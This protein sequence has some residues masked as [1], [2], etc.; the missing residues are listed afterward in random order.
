MGIG[1]KRI[2]LTVIT[3]SIR[4]RY[5]I[6]YLVIKRTITYLKRR[7]CRKVGRSCEI[8]Q[9]ASL[10]PNSF[11]SLQSIIGLLDAPQDVTPPS[12]LPIRDGYAF[13][14]NL[15][16]IVIIVVAL[17]AVIVVVVI[18]VVVIIIYHS[19]NISRSTILDIDVALKSIFFR[20]H[21]I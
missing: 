3:D 14:M 19:I 11:A 5:V 18:V 15:K 8:V 20:A 6:I 17:A 21:D 4:Q 9:L 13:P 10:Y 2:I 16:V 7:K 1:K 12:T